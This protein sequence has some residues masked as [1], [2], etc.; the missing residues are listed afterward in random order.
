MSHDPTVLANV[1]AQLGMTPAEV[2]ARLIEYEVRSDGSSVISVDVPVTEADRDEG[3]DSGISRF[4]FD[5]EGQFKSVTA[6]ESC[7]GNPIFV[8][9]GNVTFEYGNS[10]FSV[11]TQDDECTN[12]S[13][14]DYWTGATTYMSSCTEGDYTLA[15]QSE[16]LWLPTGRGYH[17][18]FNSDDP[19]AV[20]IAT[21]H[22]SRL[23]QL[24][25]QRLSE[26]PYE[27]LRDI[28][29]EIYL[30]RQY[31]DFVDVEDKGQLYAAVDEAE[32]AVNA[33]IEQTIRWAMGWLPAE[34]TESLNARELG[35][36]RADHEDILSMID[37]IQT[38]LG[39][40]GNEELI[41]SLEMLDGNIEGR[42][43]ILEDARASSTTSCDEL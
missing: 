18:V 40:E 11:S 9:L 16:T 1:G 36:L 23:E 24:D 22:V 12:T 34:D 15:D 14:F 6:T 41:A 30:T 42:I 13:I 4:V 32:A 26:M 7:W 10:Y 8:E 20:E 39:T 5:P 35:D 2:E 25:S 38:L 19:E 17:A 29:N 43:L 28:H 33:E 37:D 31:V 21:D 27:E 3:C